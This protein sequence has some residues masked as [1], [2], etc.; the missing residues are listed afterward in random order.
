MLVGLQK[1]L[2]FK[3]NQTSDSSFKSLSVSSLC[4]LSHLGVVPHCAWCDSCCPGERVLSLSIPSCY[5]P[6]LPAPF[7]PPFIHFM[8]LS[9]ACGR[10]KRFPPVAEEPQRETGG[11]DERSEEEEWRAGEGEGGGGER[12]RAHAALLWPDAEQT[13]PATGNTVIQSQALY[14]GS[15]SSDVRVDT[16]KYSNN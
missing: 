10:F 1:C 13:G 12:E 8:S 14:T 5:L 9:A 15:R 4:V 16:R 3:S 6:Y 2:H 7:H 11:R